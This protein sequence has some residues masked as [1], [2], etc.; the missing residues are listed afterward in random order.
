MKSEGLF[1]FLNEELII[2]VTTKRFEYVFESLW[3]VLK[4]YLR[5]EGLDCPTPIRC[6][7]EAFKIG[8]IQEK[9]EGIFVDMVE[10]RNQIVHV[11]DLDRAKVIYDFVRSEEVFCA[12]NNI[13]EKLK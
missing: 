6:F 9:D 13:F 5:E 7:K 1:D 12:I 8:L 4:E 11:Y 10:K 2:E 3:K